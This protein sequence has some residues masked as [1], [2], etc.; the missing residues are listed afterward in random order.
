ME[1]PTPD[2]TINEALPWSSPIP[3]DLESI[4]D[5]CFEK[6]LN[7]IPK[8]SQHFSLAQKQLIKLNLIHWNFR[9]NSS[10]VLILLFQLLIVS[11][12]AGFNNVIV[13]KSSDQM[14]TMEFGI[15]WWV[16][17]YR[18]KSLILTLL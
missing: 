13:N 6:A 9:I 15:F 16:F 10:L 12:L 1:P 18:S 5:A 8:Q 7:F 2:L 3:K 4:Q 17:L 14:E 11:A